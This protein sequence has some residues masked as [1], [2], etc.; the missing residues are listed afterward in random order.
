MEARNIKP[1]LIVIILLAATGVAL[2]LSVN[3]TVSHE[4]GVDI[5]RGL[6]ETV[7]DW[8]GD[9]LFFCQNPECQKSVLRSQVANVETCS[10]CSGELKTIS[11][12]EWKV[13]PKDTIILKKRYTNP[14][15][16]EAFVSIV[17]SGE[18]RSSIHR[19]QMCLVGQGHAIV[20]DNVVDVPL[21]DRKLGV[22]VLDLS[23]N[24]TS[25]DGNK[26][27]FASYYAYW[28]VGKNRETPYHLQRMIWMALD[29]VLF[30]RSHRWAYISIS[31]GREG[32]S[33][34]HHEELKQFVHDLYPQ[35]S[36]N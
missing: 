19:P 20:N 26:R 11:Y 22:M 28:F 36:I 21:E 33:I 14:V 31:G 4:A 27:S 35:M 32:D 9:D 24:W 1:Y 5:D 2:A 3:V 30:N 7:G 10:S 8:K 13:L 25:R 6:P 34:A 15:G 29:K 17:L 16:D 18:N 23:K 12:Q